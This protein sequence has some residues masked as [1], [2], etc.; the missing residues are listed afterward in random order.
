VAAVCG[1][2]LQKMTRVGARAVTRSA[3]AESTMLEAPSMQDV[4]LVNDRRGWAPRE[5][6]RPL[7]VSAGSR[8]AAV[9]DAA[10]ARE[11]LRRAGLEDTL[12]QRATELQP[13]PIDTAR[14]ARRAAATPAFARTGPVDDAAIEAH[15]RELLRSRAAG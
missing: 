13:P 7:T 2:L 14:T 8:A 6:P 4:P 12:R 1:L 10:A 11:A 3:V 5:L 9:L 15:V